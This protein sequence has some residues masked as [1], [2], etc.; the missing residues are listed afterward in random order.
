MCVVRGRVVT[1]AIDTRKTIGKGN[2]RKDQEHVETG[3]E[4]T[5]TQK[6]TRTQALPAH[7][8]TH[9]LPRVTY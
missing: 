9:I 6:R 3:T 8:D 1:I 2:E 5:Q 7:A 4:D